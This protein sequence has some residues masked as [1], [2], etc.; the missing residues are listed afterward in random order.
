MFFFFFFQFLENET[1]FF[2]MKFQVGDFILFF[3]KTQFFFWK[4]KLQV[5]NLILF[6][7]NSILFL[8]HPPTR[9]TYQHFKK[10][11]TKPHLDGYNYLHGCHYN[12]PPTVNNDEKKLKWR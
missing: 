11:P 10:V 7:E 2:K 3:W 6:V 9:P 4:L 1:F 8:P 12:R 5:G